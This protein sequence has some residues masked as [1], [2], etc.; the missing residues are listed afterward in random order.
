MA[1][2][3][4][5]KSINDLKDYHFYVEDYQRGYKWTEVE[6][7]QLLDDINEFKDS[8]GFYCLQPLVIKQI[9]E[10]GTKNKY[11]IIDGQQRATTI[12]LILTYLQA[13]SKFEITYRT[14]NESAEFLRNINIIEKDLK[15]NG[16]KRTDNL[17]ETLKDNIDNYHF[18][19]AYE[20]IQNWFLCNSEV[21][22]NDFLTKLNN[23]VK[24][25]WY[26]V[27]IKLHKT[28]E[29]SKRESIEIF[30]RINSGKIPLTNGEL[31]KAL[32]LINADIDTCNKTLK[33]KQVEI[34]Q[35]WDAFEYA[36][37]DDAFWYF[38]TNEKPP[39]TRIDLIFDLI[40]KK[41]K[42]TD[43]KLYTFLKYNSDFITNKRNFFENKK[44]SKSNLNWVI[45]E[46]EN[47]KLYFF[48][49]Q[50]WYNDRELYHLIGFLV[51]SEINS[52]K[53]IYDLYFKNKD[54]KSEWKLFLKEKIRSTICKIDLKNLNYDADKKSIN[55]ILLLHNIQTEINQSKSNSRY[56][57]DRHKELKWSLEHI[58]A[59][60]QN[61]LKEEN[62]KILYLEEIILH[63]ENE[64]NEKSEIDKEYIKVFKT[65]LKSF[66][67]NSVDKK[68][69][70]EKVGAFINDANEIFKMHRLENMAL[71]SGQINSALGN[72]F[73]K[74]KREAIIIADKKGE[75]IPICTRNIF[76]KYY[77]KSPTTNL[78]YWSS[79][80][81]SAYLADI[82]TT[83][84]YYTP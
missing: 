56:Q 79:L 78:F 43:D 57:F 50:D 53:D 38:L 55:K 47:V 69:D 25:I 51:C 52:I 77:S 29:E 81:G 9:N 74:E 67:A 68:Y 26:E 54:S 21:L 20:V 65:N 42:D 37:Q 76:L 28:P 40:T 44:D 58:H 27:P 15:G 34:A 14:R 33:T 17:K 60:N 13:T 6:V 82:R 19:N 49:L 16:Y 3:D 5:L 31:I 10:I 12:F 22:K 4:A 39:A 75:F 70:M 8:D 24:V 62:E 48:T 63:I 73:F 41:N 46:W 30:T 1:T 45:K 80:D 23:D 64:E 36:L 32:F 7:K 11:E 83:L 84:K 61:N 18:Y 35:Q 72:G 66:F 71:L 2:N 59:Q